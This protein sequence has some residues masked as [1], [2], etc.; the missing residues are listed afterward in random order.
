VGKEP[1]P[2]PSGPG[3][4]G[5]WALLAAAFGIGG[6]VEIEAVRRGLAQRVRFDRADIVAA[7]GESLP[8]QWLARDE[9]TTRAPG[10][11]IAILDTPPERMDVAGIVAYLER[12]LPCRRGARARVIVDGKPYACDP[13]VPAFS[14]T[15]RPSGQ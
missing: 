10:T 8:V 9:P 12:R 14:R 5:R 11:C 4:P 2:A 15:L 13:P 3:A 6:G 7:R 1:G